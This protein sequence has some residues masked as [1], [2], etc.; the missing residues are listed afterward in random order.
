M[1]SSG[2]LPMSGSYIVR[3]EVWIGSKA[4]EEAESQVF[5]W[6]LF[7]FGREDLSESRSIDLK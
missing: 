2:Q 4:V 3:R 5:R 1:S 7:T 6:C